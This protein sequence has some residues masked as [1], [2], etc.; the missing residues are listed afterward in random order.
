MTSGEDRGERRGVDVL[1]E[2]DDQTVVVESEDHA[3]VGAVPLDVR[4]VR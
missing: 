2:P 3:G 4:T 1:V